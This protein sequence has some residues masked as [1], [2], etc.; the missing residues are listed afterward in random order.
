MLLSFISFCRGASNGNVLTLGI[1]CLTHYGASKAIVPGCSA[2]TECPIGSSRCFCFRVYRK[3]ITYL[4][5][6][7][8]QTARHRLPRRS[9][10]SAGTNCSTSAPQ[11]LLFFDSLSSRTAWPASPTR[12]AYDLSCYFCNTFCPPPPRPRA[13]TYVCK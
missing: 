9:V 11:V 3:N 10:Y 8:E 6:R 1:Q 4:R 2:G 7:L 5:A 13:P 12:L